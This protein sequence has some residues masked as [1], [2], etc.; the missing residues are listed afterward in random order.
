VKRKLFKINCSDTESNIYVS[1]PGRFLGLTV[2]LQHYQRQ[3]SSS[4]YSPC[5]CFR[6]PVHL[7]SASWFVSELTVSELTCRGACTTG[8]AGAAAPLA[9][10][11]RGQAGAEKCPFTILGR[12]AKSVCYIKRARL[13]ENVSET[14]HDWKRQHTHCSMLGCTVHA[15]C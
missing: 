7:M 12:L 8:A 15:K 9:L 6:R 10:V 4:L 14:L 3:T 2:Q 5:Q 1:R 13:D 11:V